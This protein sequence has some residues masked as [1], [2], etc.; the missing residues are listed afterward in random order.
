MGYPRFL[1]I[2]FVDKMCSVWTVW[3]TWTTGKTNPVLSTPFSTTFFSR[4]TG[5]GTVFHRIHTYY[6][7]CCFYCI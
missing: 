7:Y 5:R 6:D 3:T 1:W 4:R 2:S